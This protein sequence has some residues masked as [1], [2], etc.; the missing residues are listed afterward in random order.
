MGFERSVCHCTAL[1][2]SCSLGVAAWA[3][4]PMLANPAA[5]PHNR[6]EQAASGRAQ[7]SD[8]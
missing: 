7:L 6:P 2:A 4:Q 5:P 8:V 1:Q 3:W